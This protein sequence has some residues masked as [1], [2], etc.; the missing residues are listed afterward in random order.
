VGSARTG[1]RRAWLV[2]AGRHGEHERLALDAGLAVV[3][4]PSLPGLGPVSSRDE[5][6]GLLRATY[7]DAPPRRLLNWRAQLWAFR[8]TAAPGDLVALP[9]KT[10]GEVAIGRV[11]GAYAYRPD[12]PPT[13]RH[14][15]PVEWLAPDVPRAAIG[16][17]LLHTLGAGMTVC[18][19]RRNRGA[20]RLAVLAATG[21]DP[22]R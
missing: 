5:L 19:V 3:G 21:T 11:A 6:L 12:L 4:W 16:E 1:P 8:A 15:R 14:V 7:P 20:D 13:A 22:G 17:D 2:R 18:E 9:L 10:S